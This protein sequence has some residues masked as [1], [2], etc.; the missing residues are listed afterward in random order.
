MGFLATYGARILPYILFHSHKENPILSFIQ[1]NM[2]LMIMV[3]LVFYT[4]FTFDFTDP[5]IAICA[6]GCCVLALILQVLF[7]N[8]LV[9]MFIS[10]IVY[11]T[12]T[13]IF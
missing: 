5:K 3:V 4:F 11:M 1:K 7:K 6:L 8:A 2:P 13:R 12:I 10:T 9:S